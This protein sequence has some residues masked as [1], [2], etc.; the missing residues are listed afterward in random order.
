[1]T[2]ELTSHELTIITNALRVASDVYTEDAIRSSRF[3][4]LP[5]IEHEFRE[6][7]RNAVMLADKLEDM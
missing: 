1:M 3:S 5:R 6:Y 7:S 4:Q 2:V